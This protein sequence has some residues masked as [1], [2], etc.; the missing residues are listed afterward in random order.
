MKLRTWLPD[1]IYPIL[2]Q[3][4]TRIPSSLPGVELE[5]REYGDRGIPLLPESATER[6]TFL[7]DERD[8]RP[9]DLLYRFFA[10][11]GFW[12]CDNGQI[13]HFLESFSSSALGD[14]VPILRQV[15]KVR[16]R[17]LF[18]QPLIQRSRFNTVYRHLTQIREDATRKP[19]SLESYPF[20]TNCSVH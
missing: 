19:I 13:A 6:E 12:L 1:E 10:C 17:S 18:F 20:T 16:A 15:V 7:E 2:E 5:R 8:L 9:R 3:R 14:L 11:G 4:P